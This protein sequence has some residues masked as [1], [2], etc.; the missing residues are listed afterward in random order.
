[1]TGGEQRQSLDRL[2]M[3][4]A[5]PRSYR[6]AP[7]QVEIVQ[8]HISIV[9]LSSSWV[10]KVKKAVDL[11]FLDFSTRSQRLHFCEEE[12]RLNRRL[13]TDT[14]QGVVP[15]LLD[16]DTP[17]GLRVGGAHE[18]DAPQVVDYA[19]LM[20]RLA[21]GHFMH[22]QVRDDAFSDDDLAGVVRT[23]AQFYRSHPA[24][25]TSSVW[26]DVDKIR[27][28][29]DENFDQ[30]GDH[31]GTL[32]SREVFELL[33]SEASEFM[34][35]KATL[36]AQRRTDGMVRD[37]H[38]DLR[39]DHVHITDEQ[40]CIF[41]CIEFNDRFRYVDIAA[42]VAFLAMDLD[43]KGRPDLAARLVSRLAEELDDPGLLDVLAFYKTYRAVVR[44]K[45]AAMKSVEDEVPEE[46]RADSA[47]EAR[48]YFR[49]ATNYVTTGDRPT[50]IVV[51][52]RIATGKSTQARL[53][54]YACGWRV[55][56][57]DITR[58]RLAGL[59]VL[60]RPSD[61]TR[62]ELYSARVSADVYAE[63]VRQAATELEAG[64]SVVVDA[65]FSRRSDRDRLRAALG[66]IR[67]PTGRP[68]IHRFIE[69]TSPE[70]R[71]RE[72]LR[73][74]EHQTGIASDARLADYG[75]INE[76]YEPLDR[77]EQLSSVTVSSSNGPDE[78]HREI[79]SWLAIVSR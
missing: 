6:D 60:E 35:R 59:P 56:S 43:H 22:Q 52:G 41:D 45:V 9:G 47:E 39:L 51:M 2:L 36:F 65:T 8:T 40:V 16:G 78:T 34:D 53:L 76:S 62:A 4:L 5:D 26:G 23:L 18:L 38:G 50:A 25:P 70:E 1:M 14:Y 46:E 33:R 68:A 71:V 28:S 72:R 55:V 69:I 58:K 13:C 57:S 37:C 11:G 66:A 12:V 31:V 17:S 44:A 21:D 32:V 79:L 7:E 3:L 64:H 54:G 74:R 24:T 48:S 20:R 61:K 10:L 15:I 67:S 73:Q 75:I 42:D 49:L 30:I 63:I 19:V 27:I 29:I 77:E